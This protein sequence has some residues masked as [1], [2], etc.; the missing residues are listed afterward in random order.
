MVDAAG[1]PGSTF[2]T[3]G[4]AIAAA[5]DGDFVLVRS[6][7]YPETVALDGIGLVIQAEAGASV[8]VRD[9]RV[10]RLGPTQFAAIRGLGRATYYGDVVLTSNEGSIWIEDSPYSDA[11][12]KAREGLL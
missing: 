6:G 10:E 7:T 11:M 12:L 8:T 1:G 9:I 2:T 5:S 3:I 4:A